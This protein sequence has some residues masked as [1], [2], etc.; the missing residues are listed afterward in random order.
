MTSR[1]YPVVISRGTRNNE[2][3]YYPDGVIKKLAMLARQLT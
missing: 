2:A 1:I 3:S